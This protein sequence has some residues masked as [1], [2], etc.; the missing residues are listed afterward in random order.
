MAQILNDL[1]SVETERLILRKFCIEDAVD[2]FEYISDPEVCKYAR[3]YPFK[4]IE[5]AKQIIEQRL[6]EYA[7][8][9]GGLWGAY[10][11]DKRKIIGTVGFF[12]IDVNNLKAELGYTFA[13]NYWGQGYA[14]EVAKVLVTFGFNKLKLERIEARCHG[15]NEA[16]IRVLEKIGMSYEGTLRKDYRKNGVFHNTSIYSILKEEYLKQ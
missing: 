14:T 8:H 9:S 15:D 11:R 2:V 1:P 6:K 12:N 10:H 5:E 3:W 4:T 7:S 13:R 16:S